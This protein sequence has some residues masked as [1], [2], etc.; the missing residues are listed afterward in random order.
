MDRVAWF[1]HGNGAQA[2]AQAIMVAK[3]QKIDWDAIT[4]WADADGIDLAVIE[5]IRDLAERN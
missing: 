1:V 4:E 2:R 3:H 5:T